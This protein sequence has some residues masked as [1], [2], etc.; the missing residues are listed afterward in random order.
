M[1]QMIKI[2]IVLILSLITINSIFAKAELTIPNDSFELGKIPQHSI[3]VHYFWFKSTGE[4]TLVIEKIKTGCSCAIMEL[5]SDKIAPGDSML[6]GLEWDIGK[7]IYKIGKHPYI[8]TNAQTDPY[9][10]H[11]TAEAHQRLDDSKPIA[12]LP[13]KADFLKFADM[14][15]Q[16]LEIEITNTSDEDLDLQLISFPLKEC[17]VKIPKSL[18]AG[19]KNKIKIDLKK[20]YIDKEFNR[21]ITLFVNDTNKT[22][23]TIPIKRK[24]F[25]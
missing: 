10:V 20:E 23:I 15:T 6:V 24:I 9:R 18:R 13:Y 3:A 8:Y 16:S 25:K 4:D 19:E 17:E 11:L 7:R 12:V 5:P 22:K 21:S 2:K 1:R 14:D